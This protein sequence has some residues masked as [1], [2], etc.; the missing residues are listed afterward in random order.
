MGEIACSGKQ[1]SWQY[2]KTSAMKEE[3]T[4]G[5]AFK[6]VLG[7]LDRMAGYRMIPAFAVRLL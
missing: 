1:P 2:T 6:P 7:A 5:I 4:A 3:L